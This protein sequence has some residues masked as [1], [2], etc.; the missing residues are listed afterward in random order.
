M[1]VYSNKATL[2]LLNMTHEM[3][4]KNIEIS[5]ITKACALL[6][7]SGL[8]EYDIDAE[9]IKKC[10]KSQNSD[11]GFIGNTD[12]IW[13][14]KLLSYFSEFDSHRK[15]AVNWLMQGNGAEPG[16]GRSK[17]DMHRI[18]V[19]GLALYLIPEVSNPNT[20]Q[21][22]EH[23]W[24]LEINSLTYKAAYT[25]LAFQSCNYRPTGSLFNE[26]AAW[27]ESQQQD[28]GG[29]GPWYNHPVGANVY[30]TAVATLALISLDDYL[31]N[32][33]IARAYDY[34]CR[35]QLKSGIWPYHEIEDGAGWG[36]LAMAEAEKYLGV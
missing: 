2:S 34:L 15:R 1:S 35:T 5:R 9:V 25:I 7:M 24:S 28:S 32:G 20:L 22:L 19:T 31:Y 17:R 12:T 14:V 4:R 26:T 16:F 33:A 36:L 29:F 21:W 3:F 10:I 8:S 18:P 23:T 13:N 11:G 6:L 27:L 30:C